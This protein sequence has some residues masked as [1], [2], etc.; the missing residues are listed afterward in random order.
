MLSRLFHRP[1]SGFTLVEVMIVVAIIGILASVAIPQ[2]L[3]FSAKAK[4]TESFA[5]LSGFDRSQLAYRAAS[6][7]F[8]Y[9]PVATTMAVIG[10]DYPNF[11]YYE[12][13]AGVDILGCTHFGGGCPMPPAFCGSYSAGLV[14]N[15]DNDMSLDVVLVERDTPTCPALYPGPRGIP[16]VFVSDI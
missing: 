3:R 10:F 13:P 16:F 7:T 14:G 1:A 8:V 15:I 5:V 2:F 11:K 12:F 6:D 4:R 9:G